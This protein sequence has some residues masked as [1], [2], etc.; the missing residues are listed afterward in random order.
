MRIVYQ[1]REFDKDGVVLRY[2]F[3]LDR[4]TAVRMYWE[5]TAFTV[6]MLANR[7]VIAER[8]WKGV[9]AS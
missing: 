7:R 6:Q 3:D 9:M 4:R 1:F 2:V 5:S 8:T